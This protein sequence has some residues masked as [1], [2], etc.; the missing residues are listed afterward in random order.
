[1]DQLL[2][3]YK[4]GSYIITNIFFA[5]DCTVVFGEKD[6]N[7]ELVILNDILEEYGKQS[8]LVLNQEKFLEF[9]K[10]MALAD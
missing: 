10:N 1:M 5:D 6:P 3:V 8:G 7:H 4:I 2:H 9:E